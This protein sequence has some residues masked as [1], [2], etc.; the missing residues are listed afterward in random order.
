LGNRTDPKAALIGSRLFAND[1]LGVLLSATYEKRSLWYD[2]AKTTGW[3]QIVRWAR[4]RRNAARPCK[5]AASTSTAMA[6][7]T[8]IPTFRAMRCIAKPPSA[9][10]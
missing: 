4:R 10:R 9:M 6:W 1:T 3:R 5:P 2:Q 8:S 7:A